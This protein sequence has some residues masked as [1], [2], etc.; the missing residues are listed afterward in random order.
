MVWVFLHVVR[1]CMN[2]LRV[3]LS[4]LSVCLNVH[5][6]E[7]THTC[8]RLSA[9]V[10]TT[11]VVLSSASRK[12]TYS[13]PGSRGLLSQLLWRCS[14]PRVNEVGSCLKQAVM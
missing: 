11:A 12:K 3:W 7:Y 6:Y 4:V 9:P 8:V 10:L 5:V 2:V 13:C 14:V 1:V